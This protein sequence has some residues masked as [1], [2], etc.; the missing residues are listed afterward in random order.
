MSLSRLPICWDLYPSAGMW[1]PQIRWVRSTASVVLFGEGS[2]KRLEKFKNLYV[3]YCCFCWG[4]TCWKMLKVRMNGQVAKEIVKFWFEFRDV[5]LHWAI[6]LPII[7]VFLGG[8]RFSITYLTFYF[9][10]GTFDKLHQW[11][12]Y[13]NN[14]QHG[15]CSKDVKHCE[16][17]K[18]STRNTAVF[19]NTKMK[20]S[21]GRGDV[22]ESSVVEACLKPLPKNIGTRGIC[23]ITPFQPF[24][25]VW[26]SLPDLT[27]PYKL[28]TRGPI[29]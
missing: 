1:A 24:M 21:F 14:W 20:P 22:G 13:M 17:Q 7:L 9:F 6:D 25:L 3:K 11:I 2:V 8:Q 27:L 19:K 26:I 4:V 15:G 5:C 18:T 12:S 10:P 29:V 28:G 23:E 16:T